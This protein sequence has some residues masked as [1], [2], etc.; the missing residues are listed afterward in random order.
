M[1]A[2]IIISDGLMDFFA[3]QLESVIKDSFKGKESLEDLELV[4]NQTIPEFIIREEEGEI[5]KKHILI[6]NA[7]PAPI[8]LEI[9]LSTVHPDNRV[10]YELWYSSIHEVP[11]KLLSSIQDTNQMLNKDVL[12]TPRI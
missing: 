2:A 9:E 12:F 1:R 11:T 5:L 10:E 4:R 7:E 6:E 8:Y 3:V